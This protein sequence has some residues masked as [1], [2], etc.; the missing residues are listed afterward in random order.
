MRNEHVR[1]FI[2]LPRSLD[3]F[4]GELLLGAVGFGGGDVGEVPGTVGFEDA[5]TGGVGKVDFENAQQAFAR[6]LV[7][8]GREEFHAL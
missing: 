4:A 3:H 2:G 1:R 5:T 7:F 8:D 6:L